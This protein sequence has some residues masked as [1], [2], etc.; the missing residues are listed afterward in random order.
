MKNLINSISYED[1]TK[2][3]GLGTEYFWLEVRFNIPIK[4]DAPF[5]NLKEWYKAI[6]LGEDELDTYQKEQSKS[7]FKLV[8]TERPGFNRVV[9]LGKQTIKPQVRWISGL[10]MLKYDDVWDEWIFSQY[11]TRTPVTLAARE[12][13]IKILRNPNYTHKVRPDWYLAKLLYVLGMHWD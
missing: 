11:I 13:L 12:E 4:E 5:D 2:L 9:F 8:P 10:D 3:S 7:T 1:G 6:S